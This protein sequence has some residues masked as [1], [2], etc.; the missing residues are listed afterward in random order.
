MIGQTGQ[1]I[2]GIA[3]M[4]CANF[5]QTVGASGKNSGLDVFGTN[6]MYQTIFVSFIGMIALGIYRWVNRNVLTD[7]RLYTPRP[8]TEK[9][10]L[11]LGIAESFKYIAKS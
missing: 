11:K 2:A 5:A 9:N 4:F 7:S 6:L 10:K 1:L 3:V 8:K